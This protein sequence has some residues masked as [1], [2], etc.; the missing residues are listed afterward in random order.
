MNKTDQNART[1]AVEQ[2]SQWLVRLQDD[3]VSDADLEAWGDWMTQPE[4][5][6]AFDDI[7][8]LWEA[9]AALSSESLEQAA[10]ARAEGAPA[11]ISASTSTTAA[12]PASA[13]TSAGATRTLLHRRRRKPWLAAAAIAASCALVAVGVF[14]LLPGTPPPA[15]QQWVTGK[16]ERRELQLADGSRV[17]LDAD[18]QLRVVFA[19]GHRDLQLPR[20]RAHFAVAH[21]PA[22]PFR[23]QA[24][25]IVSQ[26]IGTRFS[27]AHASADQVA[28]VV[29]EGRVRVSERAAG[30]RDAAGPVAARTLDLVRNQRARYGALGGLQ[31]P[32]PINADLAGAWKEGSVIYQREPLA[33]VVE[34]LNRYSRIPLRLEDSS[35][36]SLLVTGRWE[37]A[38][39]DT[40]VEGLAKAL[41]LEVVRKPDVILLAARKPVQRDTPPLSTP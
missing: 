1:L 40:W 17:V 25:G 16:G 28:V 19:D 9:T 24:G 41:H 11:P 31:G 20:G 18:S 14:K 26:A 2:A 37:S 34:D 23:V 22:R 30:K 8:A 36:G 15:D 27:V 7:S 4:N 39:V 10:A 33:S 6:R 5:A 13:S 32:Q 3:A 21:D 38:S 35:M 12:T 29:D